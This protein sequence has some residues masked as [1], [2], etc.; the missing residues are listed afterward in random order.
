MPPAAGLLPNADD[1]IKSG[2][3]FYRVESTIR[4][5]YVVTAVIDEHVTST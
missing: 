1:L 2:T 4:H 3:A 5:K